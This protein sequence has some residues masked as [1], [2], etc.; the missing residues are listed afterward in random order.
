MSD[1]ST[2]PGEVWQ[3]DASLAG[4]FVLHVNGEC[5]ADTA[6]VDRGRP[7][8]E[9]VRELAKLD[10]PPPQQIAAVYEATVQARM[11][12]PVRLSLPRGRHAG[13][14]L[15]GL[16][17]F[18]DGDEEPC[19]HPVRNYLYPAIK[20]DGKLVLG[21]E[22]RILTTWRSGGPHAYMLHEGDRLP[23]SM[24][25]GFGTKRGWSHCA[26]DGGISSSPTQE[27]SDLIGWKAFLTSERLIYWARINVPFAVR[28]DY[29]LKLGLISPAL[30][31]LRATFRQVHRWHERPNLYWG[32]HVRHEWVSHFGF[33]RYPERKKPL[34]GEAPPSDFIVTGFRFPV[35]NSARFHVP[36]RQREPTPEKIA[37]AY[38]EAIHASQPAAQN[39]KPT[40]DTRQ[41]TTSVGLRFRKETE[42][43]TIWLVEG[44]QPYS[45]PECF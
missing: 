26:D 9:Q 13:P 12:V 20:P 32:F 7:R 25:P 14:L 5:F 33:G 3:R 24:V 28:E 22:E 8:G 45:L 1:D 10:W 43:T 11:P 36:F 39:G 41:T 6:L 15:G 40:V 35:A 31:D 42:E 23:S 27:P 34:F 16:A 37:T 29:S 2:S 17:V 30:D 4:L 21:S 38:R 19:D 18:I 44:T